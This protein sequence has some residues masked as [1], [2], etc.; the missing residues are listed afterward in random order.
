[1]RKKTEIELDNSWE[2]LEKDW[3]H[4]YQW[5]HL[6]QTSYLEKISEILVKNFDSII[7]HKKGLREQNFNLIDHK[8]Q[9]ILSTTISQVTEKRFI[10]ALF[11]FGQDK[12]IEYFG[13][14]IDYE[15]PLKATQKADH[16]DIDLIVKNESNLLIVEAKQHKSSESILKGLLQAYVYTFL[17]NA[18]KQV[19]YKEYNFSYNLILTPAI[20][21]F[22]SASS[23]DQLYEMKNY[24][25]VLTLIKMLSEKLTDEGLNPF[26]FFI[27][28]NFEDEVSSS[29][30]TD[31][32]DGEGELILFRDDFIPEIE[33]ITI[34]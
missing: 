25:R 26:R 13:N 7:L 14:I 6:K 33:E 3:Y 9:A 18:V 8:G 5:E 21:T 17:V 20:L 30:T 2:T 31:S 32:F 27:V 24:P 28:K 1:M 19:F 29:L 10:R 23:G 15:V 11:N 12:P 4:I 16:G 34:M 22:R